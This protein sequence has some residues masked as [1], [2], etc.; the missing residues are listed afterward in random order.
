MY[1][2]DKRIQQ[3]RNTTVENRNLIKQTTAILN[4]TINLQQREF[5][6]F[7]ASLKI[8]GEEMRKLDF[9]NVTNEIDNYI[10]LIQT[11]TFEH[12]KLYNYLINILNENAQM[13][14][15]NMIRYEKLKDDLKRINNNIPSGENL[16]IDIFNENLHL[17]MRVSEISSELIDRRTST[18]TLNKNTI[19]RGN[20]IRKL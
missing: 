13:N 19:D 2:G 20:G 17:L 8:L 4:D 1:G 3:L 11:M 6:Q 5:V 18:K 16:P 15:L 14:V 10:Q 12:N 9:I 7:K